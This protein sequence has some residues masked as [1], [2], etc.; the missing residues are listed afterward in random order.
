MQTLNLLGVS[1]YGEKYRDDLSIEMNPKGY[2]ES[3]HILFHGLTQDVLSDLHQQAETNSVAVKISLR[4]LLKSE[5]YIDWS[6]L[7]R[8]NTVFL[9]PIRHPLESAISNLNFFSNQSKKFQ[10]FKITRS[11]KKFVDSHQAL[12]YQLK[13]R[14]IQKIIGVPYDL[15]I[16]DPEAYVSYITKALNLKVSKEQLKNATGNITPNLYRFR[17]EQFP[18]KEKKWSIELGAEQAYER[19][20]KQLVLEY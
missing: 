14:K 3:R 7:N 18:D 12:E 4:G 5:N 16:D 13:E 8:S 11:L 2:Y 17:S 15:A 1:F 20:T 19:L 10:F 9:V 6:M